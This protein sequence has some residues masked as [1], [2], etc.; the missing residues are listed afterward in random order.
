MMR[1][2]GIEEV[3]NALMG[4]TSS[5]RQ[6]VEKKAARASMN[7]LKK[8]VQQA[9][10]NAPVD[11]PTK[12]VRYSIRKAAAKSVTV[13]V[14]T[15]GTGGRVG[16]Y[17]PGASAGH[18]RFHVYGRLYHNYHKKNAGR[19]KLAH[20]L[21]WPHGIYR[22]HHDTAKRARKMTEQSLSVF[23]RPRGGGGKTQGKLI[24]TDTFK[25]RSSFTR[26]SYMK[27]VMLWIMRP[28]A[29][30]KQARGQI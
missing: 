6:S 25:R 9:W 13:K 22:G 28:K 19:G 7:K 10:K 21:E 11:E 29:T 17:V 12:P 4:L 30:Q 8:S 27:A 14:G 24:V 20:L 1:A 3:Q 18:S 5:K 16:K 2:Y 23:E 26:D 15:K